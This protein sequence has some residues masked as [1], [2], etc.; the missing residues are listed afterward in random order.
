MGRRAV[1]DALN[2]LAFCAE[3]LQDARVDPKGATGLAWALRSLEVDGRDLLQA[4]LPLPEMT[5]RLAAVVDDALA[6]RASPFVHELKRQLPAGLF[7]LR[8]LKGLGPKKIQR[9]WTEL[10]IESLGE[11][12]YACKENRLTSLEGFGDKT[13][14]ALLEQLARAQ[15]EAELLRRDQAEDL[16]SSFLKLC[17]SK[18]LRA[19]LAG[20]HRRGCELVGD[21][22]VVTEAAAPADLDPRVRFVASVT[23]EMFGCALLLA[24]GGEAHIAALKAHAQKRSLEL[25]Q[26]AARTE[27]D[28]YERLGLWPAAPE[29]REGSVVVEKSSGRPR[30]LQRGDVRGALHNHTTASDGV[31]TLVE[32]AAAAGAWGLQWMGISDHSQ[33]AGYAHGLD[34]GRLRAQRAD[35]DAVNAALLPQRVHVFSGVESDILKDGAL[36]YDDQD[37]LDLDVVVASMHQRFGMK[38]LALTQ[39]LIRAAEHRAVDVVGHPTGRLLLSRAAADFDVSALLE[40]CQR[41]GCAVELNANPARLDLAERWLREAKERGVLVSIAADA[42]AVDEFE[43]LHHG[44][45]LARRAGLGAD[46]VLNSRSVAELQAWVK[47]RR[48]RHALTGAA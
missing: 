3:L 4:L 32:M 46:D 8:R 18:G 2:E 42:H 44:L 31:N 28:V 48:Q 45:A 36:D 39:R 15:G 1:A 16:V 19:E 20:D 40:A 10:G 47:A 17:V 13:Q 11:L 35:V 38:G 21:V 9:L 26:I 29:Q 5:P 33:S 12:E 7:Q 22:V 14:R 37:L 41:S 6:E 34:A 43:N 23:P 27:A 25:D 30:L 24:T